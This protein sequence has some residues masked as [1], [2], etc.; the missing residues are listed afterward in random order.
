M[1]LDFYSIPYKA[2]YKTCL[3]QPVMH[4]FLPEAT[5]RLEL[6]AFS[7]MTASPTRDGYT[8]TAAVVTAGKKKTHHKHKTREQKI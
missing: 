1:N 6:A 8:H 7:V 5:G 2:L 3:I 4:S